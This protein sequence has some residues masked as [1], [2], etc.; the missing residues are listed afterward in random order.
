MNYTQFRQK[1]QDVPLIL[2]KSLSLSGLGDK[3]MQ[4]QLIRWQQRRLVI[5]L[6]RGL[7]LLNESDRKVNPSRFYIANQLYSPSYVSLESALSFY[8]LIPER[9]FDIT[10]IATKKTSRF[11]NELGLFVYQHIKP[12]CFRGFK[13]IKEKGSGGFLIADPE[14]ALVDFLY[15][16]RN[17]FKRNAIG[18]F[19]DSYRFQ[20]LEIL[21]PRKIK[22]FAGIF[23]NDELVKV[24]GEFCAFLRQEKE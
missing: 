18:L 10:S 8:E 3:Q 5:K 19:R 17:K 15:L 12:G 23:N 7:Y 2:S 4:N 21:S 11:K 6:K 24:A 9:V 14:K 22:F 20:N 13:V 16:N 1:F